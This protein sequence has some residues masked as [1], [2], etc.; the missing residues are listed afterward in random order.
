MLLSE[1]IMFG[2]VLVNP[3]EKKTLMEMALT[4]EEQPGLSPQD[5]LAEFL[6]IW[7]W[8][9]QGEV[10]GPMWSRRRMILARPAEHFVRI[11]ATEVRPGLKTVER[12]VAWIRL[13]ETAHELAD[14]AE[15][16]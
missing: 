7:P 1:A 10:V 6:R 8:T 12:L 15:A 13:L 3:G 5:A 16:A 14:E 11:W 9:I 4:G 2:T